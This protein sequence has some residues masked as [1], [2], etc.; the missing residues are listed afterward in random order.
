MKP[1]FSDKPLW[2]PQH[3]LTAYV[4]KAKFEDAAFKSAEK[5]AKDKYGQQVCMSWAFATGSCP[6]LSKGEQCLKNH[7]GPP[8]EFAPDEALRTGTM[9]SSKPGQKRPRGN[10]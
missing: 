8:G 5:K 10:G 7:S 2:A 9:P 3:N 6:R 1:L 4:A